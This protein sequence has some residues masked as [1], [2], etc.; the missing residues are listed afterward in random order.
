MDVNVES[1]TIQIGNT[2]LNSVVAASV[3]EQ[4][5]VVMDNKIVYIL[6]ICIYL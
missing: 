4:F 5:S 1:T 2:Q 3:V 6:K